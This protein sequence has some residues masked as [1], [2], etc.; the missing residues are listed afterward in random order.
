MTTSAQ[1]RDVL[2]H[3]ASGVTLV[4]SRAGDRTHGMTVSAF[5]SIS[6]EPAIVAVV[7]DRA[8]TIHPFLEDPGA[9]FAV[10][11]LAADQVGL[12][13]RFAFEKDEDRFKAGDW[14][15]AVTGAPVLNDALAW[16]DC[17][18]EG[19]HRAG[20]HTIYLGRVEAT[21]VPRPGEGPLIYW[22]RDYREL[23]TPD[24]AFS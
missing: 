3:F 19:R 23:S 21:R 9:V 12:S 15:T 5:T 18:V 1:Y 20:T 2:R 17:T 16:L 24:R 14:G 11:V 6:A 8:T 22:D 7:I 10:N 4:T 13:R